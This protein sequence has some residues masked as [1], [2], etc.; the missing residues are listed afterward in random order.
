MVWR[1]LYPGQLQGPPEPGLMCFFSGEKDNELETMV[2]EVAGMCSQV[3]LRPKAAFL[4]CLSRGTVSSVHGSILGTTT[5]SRVW[6]CQ[7]APLVS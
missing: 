7:E 3:S 5:W 2:W 6:L 1:V 4:G